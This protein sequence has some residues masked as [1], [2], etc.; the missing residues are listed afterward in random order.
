MALLLDRATIQGLLDMDQAIEIVERAFVE[1]AGE[2]V[3]MPQRLTM[4][5]AE[6]AGWT[7]L[8]PAHLKDMGAFGV[9]AVTV[10]RNNPSGFSLPSTLATII[11]LDQETGKALS[12]MDGGYITAMRTGAVSGLATKYM[13]RADVS[14][15]GGLG[16]GV[17]ARTQVLGM[18]SVRPIQKVLCFA[19]DPP[20]QQQA[21]ADEMSQRLGILIEMTKSVQEVVEQADVLAL[22]TTSHDPIVSGEWLRPGTHINSVGSHTP[23]ARELDTASVTRSKVVCDLTAACMAEAGDLLL[24]IQEGTF[25]QDKVFAE[26][27]DVVTGR[28]KGR[29]NDQEITLF[30]SVGLSVQDIAT[31]HLVYQKALEQGVGT[32][33]DF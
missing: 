22:A 6:H 32:N 18:C 7:A 20:E 23:T 30:K 2:S 12:I 27:G 31:A 3:A 29:E 26:L 15:A 11:M 28:K 24:P 1:L 25:S 33:F 4:A 19:V 9:K 5:D 8:M 10:F 16:M 21:F 14:V 13:A 17:Q